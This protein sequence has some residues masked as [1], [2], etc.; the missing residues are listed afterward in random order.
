MFK[1][2]SQ[3][4]LL[5]FIG[6]C[7]SDLSSKTLFI[8]PDND[9][10]L[11]LK[12]K[13]STGTSFDAYSYLLNHG[14]DDLGFVYRVGFDGVFT[15]DTPTVNSVLDL[16]TKAVAGSQKTAKTSLVQLKDDGGYLQSLDEAHQHTVNLPLGWFREAWFEIDLT[17]ALNMDAKT[18]FH[19]LTIGSFPFQV[20]RGIALGDAYGVNPGALGFY[21]D[22]IVD[23]YAYGVK[24]SGGFSKNFDLSYDIYTAVWQNNSTNVGDCLA[25]TQAQAFDRRP[26]S[27]RGFGKI[28]FVTALRFNILPVKTDVST[29]KFEP[30]VVYNH[31]P[32]QTIEFFADSKSKLTTVGMAIEGSHCNWEGG[33]DGA[34]NFGHQVVK[35]W[36]RNVIERLNVGGVA[37]YVFSDVYTVDP[38][39]HTIG[40]ADKLVYDA[41][42]SATRS[43]VNNVPRSTDF[44][45]TQIP[46]TTYYNSLVRFRAPYQNAYKG[47]MIVGDLGY[48]LYKKDLKFATTAGVASGDMNPN[49]NLAD[50]LASKVDGDYR[51]F[52]SLQ[53]LYAGKLVKSV[54]VMGGS[55]KLVRPLSTPTSGNLFSAVVDAFSNL[56]FTGVSL[57]YASAESKRKISINPNLLV[58]WEQFPGNKFHLPTGLS[59]DEKASKFLGTEFNVIAKGLLSENVVVDCMF[60]VFQPGSHYNDVKG[61]PFTAAQ[62]KQL[63]SVDP[64]DL[65]DT[66]PILSTDTAYSFATGVTYTF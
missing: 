1:K 2:Y 46:G 64:T 65:P 7:A 45:G 58:Y 39:N 11:G 56:I 29:L 32:E 30:Y 18:P 22:S 13:V 57:N 4:L 23:N 6:L 37:T 25:K 50:P 16:R 42:A 8:S 44:N 53:E 31:A 60:A 48:W 14:V 66:Y 41:Q 40:S 43:A 24:F 61:Q 19:S 26:D 10:E 59:I 3:L 35:G 34:M 9:L 55:K 51:G 5:L 15:I 47:Y 62:R 38:S 63:D 33:I 27:A 49:V 28:N 17:K 54:F 20:G 36:D 52:I 21:T 12:G